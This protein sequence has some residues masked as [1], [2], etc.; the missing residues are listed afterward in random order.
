MFYGGYYILMTREA[1]RKWD[2]KSR[3]S[4]ENYKQRYDEIFKKKTKELDAKR[5]KSKTSSR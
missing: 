5:E 4:T 1:G 2:G 3:I